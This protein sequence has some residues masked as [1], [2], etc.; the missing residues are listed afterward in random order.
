MTTAAELIEYLLTLPPET[1]VQVLAEVKAGY[2]SWTKWVDLDIEKNVYFS[3]LGEYIELG[4][5]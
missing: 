1:S 5:K 2:E 4:D 3:P